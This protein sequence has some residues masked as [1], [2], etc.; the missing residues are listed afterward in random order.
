[1]NKRSSLMKQQM[2]YGSGKPSTGMVLASMPSSTA[3]T[4][5]VSAS[6]SSIDL[7]LLSKVRR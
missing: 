1:M 7:S 4:S 2:I 6:D 5:S 3:F